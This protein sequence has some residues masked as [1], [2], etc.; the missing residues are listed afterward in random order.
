MKSIPLLTRATVVLTPCGDRV[1]AGVPLERYPPADTS[2]AVGQSFVLRFEEGGTCT[3]AHFTDAGLHP[4][5][6]AWTT[7]DTLIAQLDASTQRVTARQ[8]GDATIAAVELGLVV[9][10]PDHWAKLTMSIRE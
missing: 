2:L 1:C 7:P 6:L 5:A 8:V 10:V 4:V 9:H 3:P